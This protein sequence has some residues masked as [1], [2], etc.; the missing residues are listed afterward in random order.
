MSYKKTAIEIPMNLNFLGFQIAGDHWRHVSFILSKIIQ[1]VPIRLQK[2]SNNK[3]PN[4]R[5][6][7]K[8][9]RF[10]PFLYIVRKKN[11]LIICSYLNLPN[12]FEIYCKLITKFQQH[13][14]SVYVSKFQLFSLIDII[15]HVIL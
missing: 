9:K 3:S 2:N 7:C 14:L 12:C 11:N 6:F 1:N 4:W 10:L 15:L 8:L 13:D 5:K